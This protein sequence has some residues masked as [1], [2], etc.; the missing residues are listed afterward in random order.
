MAKILVIEDDPGIRKMIELTLTRAAHQVTLTNDGDQGLKS[1]R[2]EQPDLV[3]SDI[4]MPNKEGIETIM[5]IRKL[6][7]AIP[8]IAMS[9]GGLNIGTQYLGVAQKLGA[10]AILSKPF[11]TAELVDLVAQILKSPRNLPVID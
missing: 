11:R 5:E 3:I 9:G 8:I 4:V 7:P 1:F 10:N 2:A 6:A